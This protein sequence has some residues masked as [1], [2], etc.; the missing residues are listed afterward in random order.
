VRDAVRRICADARRLGIRAEEVI[1]LIKMTWRTHPE[2]CAQPSRHA[3][4]TLEQIIA[5]CIDEYFRD[6]SRAEA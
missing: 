2:I 3:S 6:P 1:V 5:M 4:S